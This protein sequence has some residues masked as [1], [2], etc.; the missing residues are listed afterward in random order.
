MGNVARA[1][2]YKCTNCKCYQFFI[3][4]II[5][6][7]L[8]GEKHISGVVIRCVGC[9]KQNILTG[10]VGNESPLSWEENKNG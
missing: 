5:Y 1:D 10:D 6:E 3:K 4:E 2:S 8:P 7:F 9:R